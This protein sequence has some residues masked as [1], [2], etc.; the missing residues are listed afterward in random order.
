MPNNPNAVDNLVPRK[1]GDPAL[2]GAGRPRGSQS[3]STIIRKL[4]ENPPDW[5]KIRFE[6]KEEFTKT[7]GS[8]RAWEAIVYVA[9]SQAMDGDH[10]AREFLAKR[11]YGDKI[12]FTSGGEPLKA[13]VE[14]VGEKNDHP[15]DDKG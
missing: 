8:N 13:L 11:G 3:L 2:P 7:Y 10:S 12:D 5:E 4:T 15:A 9:I 6:G 14:F 1:K